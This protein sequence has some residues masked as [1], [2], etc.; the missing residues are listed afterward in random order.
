MP[1]HRSPER[2]ELRQRTIACIATLFRFHGLAMGAEAL[3]R[4]LAGIQAIGADDIIR[5]ARHQDL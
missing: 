1:H 3:N 2:A 4:E 5:I